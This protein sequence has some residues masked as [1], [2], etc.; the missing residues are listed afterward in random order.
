[1]KKNLLTFTALLAVITFSNFH[2]KAQ[3][4]AGPVAVTIDL[5]D[6][7]SIVLGPAPQAVTFVYDDAADYA[8]TKNVLMSN[9]F[10]VISTKAYTVSVT[11]GGDFAGPG[12]AIPLNTVSVNVASASPVTGI[13]TYPVVPLAPTAN[14]I[15][16][17]ASPTTTTQYNINYA[18]SQANASAL[19]N[20]TPGLY[21]SSVTYSVTQ[22]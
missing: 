8:A 15:A 7:F 14:P 5:S 3:T 17:A 6:A 16:A 20:K 10:S 22:P 19:L 13:G 1:M 9:H 2:A 12:V 11:G 18:I 21:V 4:S